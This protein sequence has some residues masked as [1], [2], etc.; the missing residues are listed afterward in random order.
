MAPNQSAP[1]AMG[2]MSAQAQNQGPSA[3]AA[4]MGA[5]NAP[6][7]QAQNAGSA[8]RPGGPAVPRPPVPAPGAGV[9]PQPAPGPGM[10][11]SGPM[12]ARGLQNYGGYR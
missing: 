9:L 1:S 5:A 7:A 4:S 8:L 6:M 2:A 12:L 10:R 3:M 11:P